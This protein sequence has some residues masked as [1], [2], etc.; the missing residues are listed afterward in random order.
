MKKCIQT[1]DG[2]RFYVLWKWFLRNKWRKVGP[3]VAVI[4]KNVVHN[5]VINA[6]LGTRCVLSHSSFEIILFK[7][8]FQIQSI[9]RTLSKWMRSFANVCNYTEHQNDF[10]IKKKSNNTHSYYGVNYGLCIVY[11]THNTG[12]WLPKRNYEKIEE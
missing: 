6:F 2:V 11:D 3:F 9:Y 7:K 4:S 12:V 10:S 1:K 8:K 5:S